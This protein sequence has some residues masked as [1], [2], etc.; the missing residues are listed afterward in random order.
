MNKTSTTG[1]N[2]DIHYSA[3]DKL[4]VVKL[5]LEDGYPAKQSVLS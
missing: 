4:K 5:Y 2:R 3:A 1:P